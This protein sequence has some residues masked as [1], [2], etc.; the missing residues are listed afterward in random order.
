MYSRFRR[1]RRTLGALLVAVSLFLPFDASMA[2]DGEPGL[3]AAWTPVQASLFSSVQIFAP[4]TPVRGLRVNA[5]HG[6]QVS[7]WGIDVGIGNMT[8]AETFGVQHGVLNLVGGDFIGLQGGVL[9][10]TVDG[11]FVG[12]QSSLV[13]VTGGR[14]DGVQI[15]LV[16][17]SKGGRGIKIGAFNLWVGDAMG[18]G[19]GVGFSNLVWED[20]AGWQAGLWN[21]VG[22][23]SR[24]LQTGFA[25]QVHDAA[26]WQ[27]GGLNFADKMTGLQVGLVNVSREMRGVQIGLVNVIQKGS[28]M[29]VL[30]LVNASF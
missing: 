20:F 10:N 4:S 19:V 23:Q 24:G 11:D 28:W 2:E 22:G 18:V 13:N 14:L 26:G 27:L 12:W 7:V 30:P 3:A 29:T 1:V 8:T 9:N 17:E 25:N 16:S 5:F 15:G 6:E 21:D